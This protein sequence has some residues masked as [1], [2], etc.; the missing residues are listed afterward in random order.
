MDL[1]L[2]C[3]PTQIT[4]GVWNDSFL[5]IAGRRGQSSL[6]EMAASFGLDHKI[7]WRT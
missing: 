6:A 3:M 5:S 4:P 1:R 7:T 2:S